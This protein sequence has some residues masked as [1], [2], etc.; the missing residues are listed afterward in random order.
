M[1][2]LWADIGETLG[3]TVPEMRGLR[4]TF[5]ELLGLTG[6]NRVPEELVPVIALIHRLR[7]RGVPDSDIERE[8]RE[9][10]VGD[11][12]P[13]AVLARMQTAATVAAVAREAPAYV[14]E[15]DLPQDPP[16]L[17]VVRPSSP[18][19]TEATARELVIDLRREICTHTVEE[20]ELLH[21]M[22]QLLQT[23]ILEVR[24]LRYAF[25][26]ASSRKDRKRGKKSI[27]RLLSG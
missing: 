10:R 6:R 8:L 22:N 12:W 21:R 7:Q 14:E 13:E 9:S 2:L 27:S 1:E 17:Y 3:L 24:D 26:L 20:R 15:R 25:L 5:G 11:S 23:L 16:A 18:E 19:T 4:N